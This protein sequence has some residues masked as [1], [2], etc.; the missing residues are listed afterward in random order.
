MVFF[1][2]VT[3]TN[4]P[5]SQYCIDHVRPFSEL[6]ADLDAG[7]VARYNFITPDLC[8]D[9]HGSVG[10][11]TLG[12]TFNCLPL[13]S[14]LVQRGDDWLAS[15]VPRIMASEAYQDGGAL[16]I[17]WDESEGGDQPIGMI[18]L[19]PHAKGHGY[20]NQEHY[21][22]SSTLRTVQEIFGVGP[23]LRDAKNATNLSDLFRSY[24]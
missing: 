16:F 8:H 4:S 19:S 14:N 22:H 18:V 7:T 2:D 5:S 20:V 6:Q 10:V 3:D 21:T 13:V 11:G 1:D 12:F 23:Y 24:P 17:T 15:V 9:M